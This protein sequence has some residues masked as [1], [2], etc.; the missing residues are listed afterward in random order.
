MTLEDYADLIPSTDDLLGPF[1][2]PA[3]TKDWIHYEFIKES[4]SASPL[5]R[6]QPGGTRESALTLLYSFT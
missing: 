2:T 5:E 6:E 1:S 3:V 4:V